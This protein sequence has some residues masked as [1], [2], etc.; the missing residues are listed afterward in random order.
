[1]L[2]DGITMQIVGKF[3]IVFGVP[4]CQL[5]PTSGSEQCWMWLAF[6]YSD[7]DTVEVEWLALK[8]AC[9]EMAGKFKDV[10]EEREVLHSQ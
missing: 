9:R 8:F 3:Y 4:F 2:R 5:T 7:G 10:L 1:M 6:D